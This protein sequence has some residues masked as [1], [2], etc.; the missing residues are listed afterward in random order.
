MA[1]TP[2]TFISTLEAGVLTLTQLNNDHCAEEN[3]VGWNARDQQLRHSLAHQIGR[4]TGGQIK[5]A[6]KILNTYRKTQLKH[7]DI[8]P[9]YDD[10]AGTRLIKS[11]LDERDAAKV[12][13]VEAK[14]GWGLKW[15]APKLV[16]LAGQIG[17]AHV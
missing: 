9:F 10:D 6:W 12:A 2:H 13:E 5:I 11:V 17:R 15:S 14:E 1:T 7:L 16:T 3:G 8:P 4:W